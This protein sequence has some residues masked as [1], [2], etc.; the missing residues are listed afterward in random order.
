[1]DDSFE[2]LKPSLRF[3]IFAFL[4]LP[5]FTVLIL[6]SGYPVQVLNVLVL[7]RSFSGF[8]LSASDLLL[9]LVVVFIIADDFDIVNSFFQHCENFLYYFTHFHFPVDFSVQML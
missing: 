5:V 7:L 9:P 2:R 3:Y 6:L 4:I 1:L 8:T